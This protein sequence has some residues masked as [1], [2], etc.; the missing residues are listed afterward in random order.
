M[1]L[2]TL[3]LGFK[4]SHAIANESIYERADALFDTPV[5]ADYPL[6][7]TRYPGSKFILSWRD[8]NK[9]QQSFTRNLGAYLNMLRDPQAN[10]LPADRRCY[11]Q[12]FGKEH[13]STPEHL[14]RCYLQHRKEAEHYFASRP[15]DLLILP[16]DGLADPWPPLCAFLGV[17]RPAMPFPRSNTSGTVSVWEKTLHPLAVAPPLP[18]ALR[19]WIDEELKKGAQ[20]EEIV[21]ILSKKRH[22]IQSISEAMGSRFPRDA[23]LRR[24]KA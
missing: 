5:W 18:P 19:I 10:V 7:D 8:P 1:S 16:L 24:Q 3:E 23:W 2:A 4:T 15:Q 21:D 12:I 20:P 9:W 13:D 22:H 6:L 11:L 17:P 14:I